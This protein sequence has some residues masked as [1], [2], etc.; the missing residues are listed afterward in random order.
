MPDSGISLDVALSTA[1]GVLTL[2][3]MIAGW[4]LWLHGQFAGLKTT[5][6]LQNGRLQAVEGHGLGSEI[7]EVKEELEW[8]VRILL[9]IADR[10]GVDLDKVQRGA[11]VKR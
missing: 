3:S 10:E 6:A 11:R 4:L 9:I 1:I 2:Q 8:A 5:L 7:K